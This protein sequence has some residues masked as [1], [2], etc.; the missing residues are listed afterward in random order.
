MAWRW[1]RAEDVWEMSGKGLQDGGSA[2]RN[3]PMTIVVLAVLSA[4]SAR[5]QTSVCATKLVAA[6]GATGDHL[7]TSVA[8][9]AV[10]VASP[11]PLVR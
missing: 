6:D 11:A 8:V 5:G 3:R 4:A 7:G 1:S 9:R 2:M 10:P